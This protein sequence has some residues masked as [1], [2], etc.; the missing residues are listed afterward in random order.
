MNPASI[1][2]NCTEGQGFS[3]NFNPSYHAGGLLG[4]TGIDVGCG[5]GSPIAALADGLVYST[6]PIE[7]PAN[8]GY[9]AVFTLC[10][11]P[12]EI[13]EFTYGHISEI[14]CQIGQRVKKDA[15]IAKEGNHGA[16]YAGNILITLA[17]QAAGDQRG[18]HRHYQKRP[19]I[20]TQRLSG[21]SIQD[22]QG[23]YRD[24]AGNYYQVYDHDN[25]FAGCV[26]WTL[27]LFNRNLAIGMGGY[28]VYLLQ[29]AIVLEG[30][31][32]FMPT[33]SFGPLTFAGT[34]ALQKKHGISRTGFCG[35]LTRGMLNA[36]YHQLQ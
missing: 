26:D 36:T 2:L 32:S 21:T 30:C 28:D 35:P 6:Y 18:A 19:C 31:G 17:M 3:Q 23:T 12:L 20:K 24:G 11:T 33:G 9:T 25:G 5:Y 16:V 29:K 34:I 15:I 10:E 22:A 13:F 4:H 27:P 14:D 1:G 7:H 8:D